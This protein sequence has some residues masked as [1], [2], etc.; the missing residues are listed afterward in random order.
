[1]EKDIM[2]YFQPTADAR[3]F[4]QSNS[5]AGNAS[6]T[7]TAVSGNLSDLM[8]NAT[9]VRVNIPSPRK[10]PTCAEPRQS[11]STNAAED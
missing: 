10:P 9:V 11:A 2:N 1:M 3:G 8:R 4:F 5:S 6:L 7:S